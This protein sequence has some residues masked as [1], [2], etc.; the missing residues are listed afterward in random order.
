[1]SALEILL[2]KTSQVLCLQT[3]TMTREMIIAQAH[4]D[5]CQMNQSKTVIK[6]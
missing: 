4:L 2:H 5:I 1:M 6:H 3:V